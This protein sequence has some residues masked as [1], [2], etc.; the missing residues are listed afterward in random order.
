MSAALGRGPGR[1]AHPPAGHPDRL[2]HAARP[3]RRHVAVGHRADRRRSTRWPRP[4][5]EGARVVVQAKPTFWTKRGTLPLD[6]RRSGRSAS[7]SCSPGSSTSSALLA[8]EGLFD[9]ERKRPLPFLPRTVGL[10][11]GRASA[12][13]RD[14]VE[15]A[16]R[17]W[18]AVRFEIR[19]VA[20]QGADAVTEVIEALPRAGPRPRG[21]RH[22][23]R[24]RRRRRS[25]TCCRSR[26]EALVRAVARPRHPGRSARSATRS[27]RRCSTSSPTC[28]PPRRPTPPSGSCPT[29]AER[30]RRRRA[31]P[32]PAAPGRGPAGRQPSG[33]HLRALR[34]P[35]GHGRPRRH[36]HARAG[37]SSTR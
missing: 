5:A 35:A 2:P 11:C 15:N 8:A 32:R 9:A 34:V 33:R 14:V 26:D 16:R 7:A 12:A 13:E 19:E 10:V 24:P 3:R 31:V 36:G 21:R 6:A 4:L 29:R 28:A 20:V 30:A 18:P 23:H 27:T 37:R 25:R 1:P 17:R 22:R